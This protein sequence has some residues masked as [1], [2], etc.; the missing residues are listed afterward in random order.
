MKY[1]IFKFNTLKSYF[2]NIHST[3]EFITGSDYLGN[4]RIDIHSLDKEPTM[5]T[6]YEAAFSVLGRIAESISQI[7]ETYYGTKEFRARKMHEVFKN[8]TV[9]F[10][11]PHDGGVGISQN[12][13]SVK[14]EWKIDLSAED[15]FAYTDNYGTSEEKAF[16]AYFRS[17]VDELRKIY[18]KI[19]LV[20]NEREFHLYSFDDGERFEPDYVLFL[21]KKKTDGYEQMQIFIEPKGTHLLEKDA[22]KERFL[23]QMKDEAIPVTVFKDD[24][25]YRIWGF[26][27]YNEDTRMK[28]FDAD[29][30][31]LLDN[32]IVRYSYT[33]VYTDYSNLKVAEEQVS[34]GTK[35][36]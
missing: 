23:L 25:D 10:T 6:L 17:Y 35:K 33:D 3:R 4:V 16:V 32:G 11:D 12:D 2:P 5:Q 27:F 28:D 36:D 1:P 26:H 13:A 18:S 29:F 20:R 15:W 8:K 24:N 30:R 9:N 21:Q 31:T 14:S 34:Y 7:E 22:W 19:Y